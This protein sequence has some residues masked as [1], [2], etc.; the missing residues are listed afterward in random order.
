MARAPEILYYAIFGPE[1][2]FHPEWKAFIQGFALKCRNGFTF[3]DVSF[4]FPTVDD[5]VLKVLQ[6]PKAFE[7]GSE[8]FISLLW[9]SAVTS[10]DS[11]RDHSIIQRPPPSYTHALQAATDSTVTL[12]SLITNF[13]Q[14]SGSP[15]PAL[16]AE[17]C[18]SFS[19]LV[20]LD[21][22]D[23]PAF[24]SRMLLWAATGSPTIDPNQESLTVGIQY[25]HP[26]APL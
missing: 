4:F 3:L 6:I 1:P 13:L 7:G 5:T 10:Y 17:V 12:Y 2:P 23:T 22:I 18:D 16:F 26:F 9:T 24:R 14:G 21:T 11:I 20:S 15:C 25:F 19:S 8:A